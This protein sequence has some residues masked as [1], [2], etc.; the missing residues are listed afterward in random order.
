[1]LWLK[2]GKGLKISSVLVWCEELYLS[3]SYSDSKLGTLLNLGRIYRFY[4]LAFGTSWFQKQNSL[5]SSTSTSTENDEDEHG[6]DDYSI[7]RDCYVLY[8]KEL[9]YIGEQHLLYKRDF[10]KRRFIH[11]LIINVLLTSLSRPL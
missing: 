10:K 2:I 1:M 7:G 8:D 3:K 4:D 6:K 9:V 5:D 11:C